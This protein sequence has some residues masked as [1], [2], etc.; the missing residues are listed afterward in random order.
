M[1]LEEAKKIGLNCNC[2]RCREAGLYSRGSSDSINSNNV[3]EFVE[4]YESSK[5]V[6]KFISLES[7]D[8]KILFGFL[9]LRLPANSFR[10]EIDSKTALVREL[11]IFGRALA[12]GEHSQ[13]EIQHSGFGERLLQRAEEI[14]LQE[15]GA[16]KLLVI[17]GLGTKE[18]YISNGFNVDG[19]FVS[20]GLN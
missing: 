12:L 16:K 11:R 18:Y 10:K 2:I 20:K 14:A 3:K 5:G 9:R 17:S 15:F 4:T 1:A 8:R 7:S 13:E 19:C 6:E